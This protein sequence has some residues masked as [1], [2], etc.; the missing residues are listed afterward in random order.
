M[1]VR[2]QNRKS[3]MRAYVFRFAPA[4]CAPRSGSPSSGG[5]RTARYHRFHRAAGPATGV[6]ILIDRAQAH[7]MTYVSALRSLGLV[8]GFVDPKSI[9]AISKIEGVSSVERERKVTLPDPR[10]PV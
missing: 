4:T 6:S 3:S 5:A 10:S 7:G 2:G 1:S 9:D 8:K